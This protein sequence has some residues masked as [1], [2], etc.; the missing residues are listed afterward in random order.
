M[1]ISLLLLVMV[2]S[3]ISTGWSL[4]V[5][6]LHAPLPDCVVGEDLVQMVAL[7]VGDRATWN[8]WREVAPHAQE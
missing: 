8:H 2:R 1:S 7:V 4:K 3:T 6:S 5:G